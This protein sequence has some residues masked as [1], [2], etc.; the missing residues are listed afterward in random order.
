M[1]QNAFHF[2]RFVFETPFV[3]KLLGVIPLKH[4]YTAIA[5]VKNELSLWICPNLL[6]NDRKKTLSLG[7]RPNLSKFIKKIKQLSNRLFYYECKSKYFINI[8]RWIHW[9]T[10]FTFTESLTR[11]ELD[12]FAGRLHSFNF[13]ICVK[14]SLIHL[15]PLNI[16]IWNFKQMRILDKLNRWWENFSSGCS[17]KGMFW[18]GKGKISSNLATSWNETSPKFEPY[19]YYLWLSSIVLCW[20]ILFIFWK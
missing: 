13:R 4:H 16:H 18:R 8:L 12:M 14:L 20:G 2:N 5:S 10:V 6:S 1:P 7:F 17:W 11:H 3:D 19:V 15:P 9:L